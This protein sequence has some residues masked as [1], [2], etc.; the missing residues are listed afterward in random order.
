M[1]PLGYVDM[2][3]VSK[4]QG[5]VD[6]PA[7]IE[8]Y[9]AQVVVCRATLGHSY[10]DSQYVNNM[11]ALKPFDN[12]LKGAYHVITPD[13]DAD[14]HLRHIE[15]ALRDAPAVDFNVVDVEL[16]KNMSPVRIAKV[17]YEVAVGIEELGWKDKVMCYT[18]KWF[19]DPDGIQDTRADDVLILSGPTEGRKAVIGMA[20]GKA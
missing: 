7:M 13:I 2:I 19:W 6:W 8:R 16:D 12:V 18:A 3:D 4:W 5:V 9:N 1:A 11:R 14:S 20:K 15:D 10:R 17:F